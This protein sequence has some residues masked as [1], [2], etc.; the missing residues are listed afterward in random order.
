[1]S[2][3]VLLK[4]ALVLPEG[5]DLQG[6][7]VSKVRKVKR[8][9]KGKRGKKDIQDILVS[10]ERK[11]KRVTTGKK[12][13]LVKMEP[14]GL[15]E[16]KVILEKK[17]IMGNQVRKGSRGKQDPLDQEAKGVSQVKMAKTGILDPGDQKDKRATQD[18][19]EIPDIRDQTVTLVLG[20][21][22]EDPEVV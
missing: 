1:M 22:P 2:E 21:F 8:E 13:I 9:I 4:L 17:V 16:T 15:K 19:P 20:E 14:P 11:G 12:D 5:L 6:Y 7:P 18:L 3:I 10:K